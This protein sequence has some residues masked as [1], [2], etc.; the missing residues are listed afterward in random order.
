PKSEKRKQE[1]ITCDA[2]GIEVNS[3][4]M[5][6]AHIRGQKH[7]KKMK[8][9]I[10]T[11]AS[12]TITDVEQKLLCLPVEPVIGTPVEPVL[13]AE[14]TPATMVAKPSST[15][16]KSVLQLLN[17]LAKFNKV[18]AK[19]D[20]VKETGPAHCK[21]FEIR[22][23]IAD[24]TYTG[25]GT[26]IKRAQQVAAEQALQAT[27]LK[28]PELAQRGSHSARTPRG[29]AGRG[30]YSNIRQ[31]YPPPPPP[32]QQ[33]HQQQSRPKPYTP[34]GGQQQAVSNNENLFQNLIN[35]K[36]EEICENENTIITLHRFVED[37][38]RA[39]KTVSDKIMETC[40]L[41]NVTVAPQL[42]D[43][44]KLNSVEQLNEDPSHSNWFSRCMLENN[45]NLIVLRL[46]RD[47]QY[48]QTP[49]SSLNLWC[50]T[51]LVYKCQYQPPNSPTNL[52]RSVFACLSSGI[53]L[54]SH[55]GPGIIDPCEKELVDAAAYLTTEERFNLTNYAQNMLRLISFEK[56][57]A[58]FH[59]KSS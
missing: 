27:A 23:I 16:D 55:I 31:Q 58:L 8:L 37:I 12:P 26:S 19:Y 54:P 45:S 25:I 56:Y 36:C 14:S 30:S 34:I 43:N 33:Q 40:K 53:L 38:E 51:L 2:C 59:L 9:K 22:L 57:D 15:N 41:N 5:M 3:Q 21:Q 17:E 29:G 32:Q 4:Q 18:N 24:E 1:I 35:N 20:L 13:L 7:I 39:L 50:L 6:D 42:P 48:N 49:L 46:L 11:V 28:R 44:V 52:F 47:L 10:S